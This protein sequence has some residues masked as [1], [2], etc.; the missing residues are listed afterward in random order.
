MA[1]DL[2]TIEELHFKGI[3]LHEGMKILADRIMDSGVS[4]LPLRLLDFRGTSP[5]NDTTREMFARIRER[6]PQVEVRW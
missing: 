1:I 6:A 5:N 2:S 3:N 4:P